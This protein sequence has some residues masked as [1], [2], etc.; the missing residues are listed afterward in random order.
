MKSK[1]LKKKFNELVKRAKEI[2]NRCNSQIIDFI[3]T[4][5]SENLF[6][7]SKYRLIIEDFDDNRFK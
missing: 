2:E 6:I 3:P 7:L 5:P 1:K 4:Y